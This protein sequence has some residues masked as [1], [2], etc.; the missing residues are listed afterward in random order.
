MTGV[1]GIGLG[2]TMGDLWAMQFSVKKDGHSNDSIAWQGRQTEWQ[3]MRPWQVK[4]DKPKQKECWRLASMFIGC[5]CCAPTG[6]HPE[7]VK[8]LPSVRHLCQGFAHTLH[9]RSQSCPVT[10]NS[11]SHSSNSNRHCIAGLLACCALLV[12]PG[13]CC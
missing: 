9:Q 11:R 2:L 5:C 1:P 12:C 8:I 4:V 3:A 7:T 10:A 6:V 13:N